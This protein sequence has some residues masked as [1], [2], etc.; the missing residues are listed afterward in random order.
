MMMAGAFGGPSS[1]TY[2]ALQGYG[3]RSTPGGITDMIKQWSQRSTP[4]GITNMISGATNPYGGNF[5]LT[6][7]DAQSIN[8]LMNPFMGTVMDSIMRAGQGQ[9]AQIGQQAAANKAFGGSAYA[10]MD[11]Q[12]REN[13]Q[14]SIGDAMKGGYD[15]AMQNLMGIRGQQLSQ[16]SQRA[17]QYNTDQNRL[18]SAGSSLASI[19]GNDAQRGMAGGNS[20]ASIFGNDMQRGLG[21]AGTIAGLEGADANR[22]MQGGQNLYNIGQQDRTNGVQD[23]SNLLNYGALIRGLNQQNLDTNYTDYMQQFQSPMQTI[24]QL[25][26]LLNG[27]P[28]PQTQTSTQTGGPSDLQSILGNVANVATIGGPKGFGV[29]GQGS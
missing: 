17:G 11:A 13:E 18:L 19:F 6:N 10:L 9:R 21:A 3:G 5:D 27:V 23:A 24:Q 4:G 22:M 2:S 25:M 1:S 12:Q 28:Y 8:S 15:T 16:Q 26:G 20:L 29:W 7:V 14:R